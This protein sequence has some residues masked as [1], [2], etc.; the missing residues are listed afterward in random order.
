MH[1]A[2]CDLPSWLYYIKPLPL[3]SSKY[4]K[5]IFL[6]FVF[7]LNVSIFLLCKHYAIFNCILSIN[8]ILMSSYLF[9][10][11]SLIV[12][13]FTVLLNYYQY[14]YLIAF[15]LFGWLVGGFVFFFSVFQDGFSLFNNPSYP[16]TLC[17]PVWPRT[18]RDQPAYAFRVPG[19]QACAITP[20]FS[21][22]FLNTIFCIFTSVFIYSKAY[23]VF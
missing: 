8:I 22:P 11:Y 1:S 18:H 5:D 20:G 15:C 12:F 16:G 9:W 23:V 7:F 6:F 3:N 10:V 21:L 4:Y 2:V 13:M 14:S 19:P 17:R